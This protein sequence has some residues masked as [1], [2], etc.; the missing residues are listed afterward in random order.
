[1]GLDTSFPRAFAKSQM[2]VDSSLPQGGKAFVSVRDQDKPQA[3]GLVRSLIELGF[4]VLATEGTAASMQ[5]AGLDVRRIFKV[6]EGRPHAV[7]LMINN[8]IDLVVN[9]VGGKTARR[10]SFPLLRT[11]LTQNVPYYTTLQGA[12]AAV[13]GI[14]AL[15]QRTPD[16]RSLQE[17][18]ETGARAETVE[19]GC[20]SGT[21]LAGERRRSVP[22]EPHHRCIGK[23]RVRRGN[24]IPLWTST[25]WAPW[26]S[27]VC[28][29]R[30]APATRHRASWKQQPACSTLS[31]S[32]TSASRRSFRT[33][34]RACGI[35]APTSVVNFFGDSPE[36]YAA[37]A[38]RASE[39]EGIAALEANISCPN[40]QHGGMLFSSD[41]RL[42]AEV[43]R[44]ARRA[45][46]LPLWVKLS[47]QCV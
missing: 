19:R 46:R 7:D 15:R 47:P 2:S 38:T 39:A 18:H 21:R 8:D 44:E 27:K 22:A 11:A 43:V 25:V 24:C 12:F 5:A 28:R 30:R 26:R 40:V 42:T 1:M 34:C 14:E 31:V 35:T 16:V 6:Q 37:V 4:E 45:T 10:D 41:P 9:T 36:E 20:R 32:R 13:Q 3:V 17:Y 29:S 23:L 33:N